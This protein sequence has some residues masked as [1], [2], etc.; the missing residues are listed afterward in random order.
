MD[1][2]VIFFE[3]ETIPGTRS[4]V[5]EGEASSSSIV[6][7]LQLQLVLSHLI[8]INMDQYISQLI[9]CALIF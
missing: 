9:I 3:R 5:I 4:R 8:L 1:T 6:L 2:R 7:S